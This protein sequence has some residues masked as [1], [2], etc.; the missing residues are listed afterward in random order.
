MGD[1]VRVSYEDGP[2]SEMVES[3]LNKYEYGKFNGMEDIYEDTN[4]R[5]DIPQTKYLFVSRSMSDNTKE[6]LKREQSERWG[7]VNDRGEAARI[8]DKCPLPVGAVVTGIKETGIEG[9]SIPDFYTLEYTGGKQ[10]E[11]AK[12][13]RKVTAGQVQIIEHPHPTRKGYLLF[14]LDD[15]LL[16][17]LLSFLSLFH[18][19]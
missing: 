1:H 16:S 10:I 8:W 9:G 4:R 11:P 17:E 5:D 12:G 7:E 19:I 15:Q 13:E 18:R 6:V 2:T 3:I 14:Q